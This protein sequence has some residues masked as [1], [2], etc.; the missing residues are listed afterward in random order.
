MAQLLNF[1]LK[2]PARQLGTKPANI[3]EDFPSPEAPVSSKNLFAANFS[4]ISSIGRS[5]PLK[6]RD[7]SSSKARRPGYG[8]IF[9]LRFTILGVIGRLSFTAIAR[10]HLLSFLISYMN[11]CHFERSEESPCTYL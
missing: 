3:K 9:D 8:Q 10:F 1:A 11:G 5:L 7:S 2:K 4:M 6:Y